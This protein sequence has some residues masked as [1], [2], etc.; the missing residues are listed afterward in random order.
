ML[1]L[2]FTGQE[3]TGSGA[4]VD[5]LHTASISCNGKGRACEH[6]C[7]RVGRGDGG[8][9]MFSPNCFHFLCE[10]KSGG[11]REEILEV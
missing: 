9:R 11:G 3:V 1:D 5:I 8:L 6:A 7:W 10:I 4:Q 2:V